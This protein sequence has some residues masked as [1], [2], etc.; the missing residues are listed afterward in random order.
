MVRLT[1][2]MC[3][4]AGS[5]RYNHMPRNKSNSDDMIHLKDDRNAH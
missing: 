1:N 5:L 2:S 3:Q 4:P